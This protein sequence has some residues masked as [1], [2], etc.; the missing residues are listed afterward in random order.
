MFMDWWGKRRQNLWQRMMNA[1]GERRSQ[2]ECSISK[3]EEIHGKEFLS[4]EA[5]KNAKLDSGC[6]EE[7]WYGLI[8]VF[9]WNLTANPPLCSLSQCL[10]LWRSLSPYLFSSVISSLFRTDCTSSFKYCNVSFNN[11]FSSAL[12]LPSL[13]ALFLSYFFQANLLNSLFLP[14]HS[15]FI[16]QSAFLIHQNPLP[17]CHWLQ[18]TFSNLHLACSFHRIW[19]FYHSVVSLTSL[20]PG[21]L[22][23]SVH[24]S[25]SFV[26]SSTSTCPSGTSDPQSSALDLMPVLL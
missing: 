7:N 2:S 20:S 26:E 9:V 5:K 6:H 4:A 14:P 11:I 21:F 16:P 10:L 18:W 23:I 17:T 19:H 8:Y 24:V 12:S 3:I 25:T 22:P 15:P 13:M 1:R